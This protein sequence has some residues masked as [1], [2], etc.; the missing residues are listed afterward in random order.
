MIEI[1]LPPGFRPERRYIVGTILEDFLGLEISY[2]EHALPDYRFVLENRREIVVRDHFFSRFIDDADH[3][4]LH[5]DN[6]PQ[7]ISWLTNPFILEQPLP[8]IFGDDE[9]D[10]TGDRMVC[11]IDIFGSAFF[12]LSRW[13]EYVLRGEQDAF[14]THGRF[15]ATSSLAFR[16]GFIDR[17]VVN[18]YVEMFWGMLHALGIRQKRLERR[19]S[20][21]LTHDVDA[22]LLWRGWGHVTRTAAADMLKRLSPRSAVRRLREYS[23][24]AR[25]KKKDPYDVYDELMDISEAMNLTSHFYF[26][27][28]GDTPFDR[29]NPY[30]IK[31]RK[32]R[33]ALEAIRTRNHIV[34]F[35]P[36][37]QSAGDRSVWKRELDLLQK[38]YGSDISEGR[39]HYLKFQVPFTWRVWAEN[40]MR[41]DSTCGFADREGFRCGTGDAYRVFDILRRQE[42]SIEERPLVFME[43][44]NYSCGGFAGSLKKHQMEAIVASARRVNTPVTLLF[45]NDA[46]AESGLRDLYREILSL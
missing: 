16:Q 1:F 36:S 34:G 18:E 27:C 11:G 7:R 14:D 21:V 39:Q 35:H 8:V 44:R 38:V 25:G 20:F 9:W 19:F 2:N 22:L 33:S 4:Y 15:P 24:I 26:K 41:I 29:V 28:G 23:L 40:G 30:G 6:I 13:E 45:H 43:R 46:M 31:S 32:A 42:L 3:G 17:P 5:A 12:M 37:Y 10:R